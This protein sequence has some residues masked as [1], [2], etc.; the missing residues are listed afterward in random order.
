[1]QYG[2]ERGIVSTL[3]AAY[4]ATLF[5]I[6]LLYSNRVLY[7]LSKTDLGYITVELLLCPILLVNILKKIA[8]RQ[9]LACTTDLMEHYS[10][11]RDELTKRLL[12]Y[13]EATK[14]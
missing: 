7:E 10:K 4:V 5:G 13:G 8:T 2:I 14:P 3:P 6:S 9:E 12:E 1:L 11:D